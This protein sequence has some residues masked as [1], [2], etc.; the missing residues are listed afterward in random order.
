METNTE[1]RER[2]SPWL[3]V[4]AA[5]FATAAVT[6][7]YHPTRLTAALLIVGAITST[8]LLRRTIMAHKLWFVTAVVAGAVALAAFGGLLKL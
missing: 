5:I 8:F 6:G 3:L 4:P 1:V 2:E 7:W